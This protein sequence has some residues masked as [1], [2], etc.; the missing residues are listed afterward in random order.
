VLP[1]HAT[2]T[3]ARVPRTDF[4]MAWSPA[5][6][7]VVA[8]ASAVIL[9]L[10]IPVATVVLP[11]NPMA[12]WLPL[13]LIGGILSAQVSPLLPFACWFAT[14][15]HWDLRPEGWPAP[16]GQLAG[17]ALLW[18]GIAAAVAG[19][20]MPVWRHPGVW[21]LAA[22]GLSLAMSA[23]FSLT[24]TIGVSLSRYPILYA[25]IA[26]V[27]AGSLRTIDHWRALAWVVVVLTALHALPG[28]QQALDRGT[29][30]AAMEGRFSYGARIQGTAANPITFGWNMIYAVPA[31]IFLV[32]VERQP[33]LKAV[34]GGLAAF[35]VG[36]S[37]LTFNRQG[38]A[39]AAVAIGA[40]ILLGPY[41]H[42]RLMALGA[43]A[44]SLA[45]AALLLPVMVRRL[46]DSF[47]ADSG[48]ASGGLF[49]D[50]SFL[51]RHD[52]FLTGIEALKIH[53]YFG[54]GLGSFTHVWRDFYPRDGS[55]YYIQS[56]LEVERRYLDNGYAQVL[57]E[58]GFLGF[59]IAAGVLGWLSWMLLQ[60]RRDCLIHNRRHG[61][62]VAA[63]L[64]GLGV[65]A[66]VSTLVQDTL[67]NP[68]IWILMGATVG[69][70]HGRMGSSAKA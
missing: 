31:A 67:M 8:T 47:R 56:T 63:W 24:P 29:I 48:G 37:L 3:G 5:T 33:L 58:T 39:L 43:G 35:A 53:P 51:E 32:S 9:G 65:F 50:P 64:L 10:A 19:R 69:L 1:T 41:R 61:A 23:W 15:F 20:L 42:R 4:W 60:Y 36:V 25:L 52:A 12:W 21:L 22:L 2:L 7:L 54:I 49:R 17:A 40:T 57:V 13:I 44:A 34:A 27:L 18:S 16:P 62:L 14:L 30:Q 28:L 66:A 6:R 11:N 59:V 46:A 45:G 70:I 68:R 38:G 55:T 26:A